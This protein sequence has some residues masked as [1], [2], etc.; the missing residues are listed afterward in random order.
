MFKLLA[1]KE[2]LPVFE[3]FIK[4]NLMLDLLLWAEEKHSFLIP[5][6]RVV[7]CRHVGSI[8][9]YRD[10]NNTFSHNKEIDNA[11]IGNFICN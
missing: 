1:M 11:T 9:S 4:S 7:G 5:T 6:E 8:I 3:H 2:L 10:T